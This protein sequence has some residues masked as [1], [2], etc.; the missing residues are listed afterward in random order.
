MLQKAPMNNSLQ[1]NVTQSTKIYFYEIYDFGFFAELESNTDIF[2]G[3]EHLV[4]LCFQFGSIGVVLISC[5]VNV[6]EQV[7]VER[8]SLQISVHVLLGIFFPDQV[9]FSSYDQR[10][11]CLRSFADMGQPSLSIASKFLVQSVHFIRELP[12]SSLQPKVYNSCQ[13]HSV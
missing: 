9:F 3:I 2:T 7:H 10:H 8:S 11:I 6:H 5:K 4:E 12:T 1:M 13:C